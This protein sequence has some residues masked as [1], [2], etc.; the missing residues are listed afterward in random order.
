MSPF[1]NPSC[2]GVAPPGRPCMPQPL[3]TT[4]SV[5]SCCWATARRWTPPTARAE[6]HSWWQRTAGTWA[7]WVSAAPCP[8]SPLPLQPP[9]PAFPCSSAPNQ[10]G[11]WSAWMVSF[12][13][14]VAFHALK[15][16]TTSFQQ[17]WWTFAITNLSLTSSQEHTVKSTRAVV[18]L[19]SCL[20]PWFGGAVKLHVW[21]R[22]YN[23]F[24]S[25]LIGSPIL[26]KAAISSCF[27]QARLRAT[28][29]QIGDLMGFA[30]FL[31]L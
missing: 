9:A 17:S 12:C 15:N 22:L 3:P 2:L 11:E 1:F 24:L 23:L 25:C 19:F 7:P 29:T 28:G 21:K 27:F 20:L 14:K 16:T 30:V 4:W 31:F 26:E 8:C 6:R 5:C 13:K 10:Q 18:I